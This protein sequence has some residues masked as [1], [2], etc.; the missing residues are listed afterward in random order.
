MQGRP[1]SVRSKAKG[2]PHVKSQGSLIRKEEGSH[3]LVGVNIWF[4][5]ALQ[6]QRDEL[7]G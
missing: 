6:K 4:D 3:L 1:K 7:Y 5:K 2:L